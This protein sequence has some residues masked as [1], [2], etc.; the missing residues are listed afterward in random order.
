MNSSWQLRALAQDDETEWLR[1]RSALW[2]DFK[3]ESLQAEMAEIKAD[4]LQP[5]FV[6][7]RT[8]GGLGGFV[9]VALRPWA[10]GCETHPVGYIEAWYVDSD[11]R[12]K[13]A[14]RGLIQAAESWAIGQ[15]CTEMASDCDLNNNIS[16]QAHLALGYQEYNRIIQFRK[17]LMS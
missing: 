10:E 7:A 5:V 2:P 17:D 16:F 14:G 13:G 9:E 15:G 8:G 4:P 1:M 6:L 12:K 11:L 3:L